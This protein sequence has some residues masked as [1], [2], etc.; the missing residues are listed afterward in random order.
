V[1]IFIAVLLAFLYA[2]CGF[3]LWRLRRP[4]RQ[5]ALLDTFARTADLSPDAVTGPRVSA[6]LLRR[7]RVAAVGAALLFTVGLLVAVLI[8]DQLSN[9]PRQSGLPLLFFAPAFL[10]LAAR[11]LIL[12]GL[13]AYDA[14]TR[15]AGPGPRVARIVAPS[16]T[17][18]VRRAEL[19]AARLA[20][21]VVLPVSALIVGLAQT[22]RSNE[23]F[24][25]SGGLIATGAI[26]LILLALVELAARRIVGLAQPAATAAELAWD[27]AIRAQQ[28]RELYLVLAMFSLYIAF[29]TATVLDTSWIAA[30]GG[31]VVL[32]ALA[33]IGKP[34][35]YYRRRLWPWPTDGEPA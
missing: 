29:F 34:S 5:R 8:D 3:Q 31:L 1:W 24:L 9:H 26:G 12:T 21:G 32:L 10:G 23:P 6:Q 20:A 17:D 33:S 16:I 14:L 35:A 11:P 28:L 30:Y 7:E 25:S 18:Y 22:H 4:G 13:L 2:V 27:D 19:W 15:R